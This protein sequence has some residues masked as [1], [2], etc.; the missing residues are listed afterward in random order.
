MLATIGIITYSHSQKEYLVHSFLGFSG[1][2][3]IGGTLDI[4]AIFGYTQLPPSMPVFSALFAIGVTIY[5]SLEDSQ[6]ADRYEQMSLHAQDPILV[7]DTQGIIL[8]PIRSHKRNS[9]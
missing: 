7:V 9:T 6:F 3:F 5:L 1:L 8:N 4:L 2:L